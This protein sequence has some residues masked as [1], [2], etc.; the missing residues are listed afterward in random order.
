MLWVPRGQSIAEIE[1]ESEKWFTQNKD[2]KLLYGDT[3]QAP[4]IMDYEIKHM[5]LKFGTTVRNQFRVLIAHKKRER[6]KETYK[7]Y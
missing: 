6:T 2:H 4:K 7:E 5:V 3:R 1:E